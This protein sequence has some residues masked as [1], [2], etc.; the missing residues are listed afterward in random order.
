ML[1][2]NLEKYDAVIGIQFLTQQGGIIECGG[3]AMDFPKFGIKI[4][5]TPTSVNIGAAVIITVDMMD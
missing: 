5:C 2:E 1:V 4:N 3:L